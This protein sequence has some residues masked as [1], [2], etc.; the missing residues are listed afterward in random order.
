MLKITDANYPEYKKI[1]QIFIEFISAKLPFSLSTA[2][3]L[4]EME[5]SNKSIAK[6]GLKQGLH[7]FLTGIKDFPKNDQDTLNEK[8]LNENLPG[9]WKLISIVNETPAK[10]LKRGKIR[11]IDEWYVIKEFLDD[12]DSEISREERQ[13]LEEYFYEFEM[14]S[15]KKKK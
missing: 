8:L 7:D 13:K 4:N 14:K 6:R 10:V 5:K 15:T 11:D 9:L 1:F 3:L 12:T 2:N